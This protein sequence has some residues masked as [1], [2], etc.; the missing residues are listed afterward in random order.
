MWANFGACEHNLIFK[1]LQVSRLRSQIWTS[2]PNLAITSGNTLKAS[3]SK[4]IDSSRELGPF[5]C[6]LAC[7]LAS[8]QSSKQ[9]VQEGKV[10]ENVATQNNSHENTASD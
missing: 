4:R 10:L 9:T 2:K 3:S 6:F 1:H 5:A 8:F 7:L